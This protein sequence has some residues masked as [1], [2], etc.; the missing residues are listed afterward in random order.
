M[1]RISES[2]SSIPEYRF[3]EPV[4]LS[5][6]DGEQVAVVGPNGAGKSILAKYL[7]SSLVLRQGRIEY[8]FSPEPVYRNLRYMAFRDSY[9]PADS[10]YYMQQRWNSQDREENPM[11]VLSSGEMRKFQLSKVL[12]DNPGILIIDQPFIGLDAPSRDLFRDQLAEL[13]ASGVQLILLLTRP[14]DI[15]SFITHVV[16]VEDMRCGRKVPVQEYPGAGRQPALPDRE[17]EEG[18]GSSA[19]PV[20]EMHD[21]TIRYGDRTILRNLDWTVG[22]GE[23][24]ALLGPNGSGKSTL[25]SLICADNPQAYSCNISLFGRKRGSGESIWDIKKHI[26]YVSPEMQRGY[27]VDTSALRIVASGFN[28]TVGLYVKPRPEQFAACE[29]WME[30]FGI[31]HLRDRSFLKLS[32]GEQRLVLLARAFVKDP[33]LLILDEPMHGLDNANKA[34]VQ[35]II[36]SFCKDPG[37]T[38]IMV[39]HYLDEIPGCITRKKVGPFI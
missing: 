2:V 39:T 22:K 26:G 27:R 4:S 30:A 38:M 10:T 32:D 28:D 18:P 6:E 25:L 8:G 20:I 33:D 7:S 11:S 12:E 24:W 34:R 1:I 36:E 21:V 35:D 23:R 19:D 37:K 14:E 13:A 31:L 15:P 5:V 3:K 9:G 17:L 29:K 16:P